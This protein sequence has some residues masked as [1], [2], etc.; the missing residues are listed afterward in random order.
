MEQQPQVF[1]IWDT[2]ELHFG[3]YTLSLQPIP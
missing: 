3:D 2:T 1:N